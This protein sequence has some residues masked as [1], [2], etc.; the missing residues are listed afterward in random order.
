MAI[1]TAGLP[2]DFF[3]AT[4]L[5]ALLT[6]AVLFLGLMRFLIFFFLGFSG[7]AGAGLNVPGGCIAPG[8][9]GL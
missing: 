6:L 1:G 7:S 9:G 8:A 3:G 5:G 4:L 2:L